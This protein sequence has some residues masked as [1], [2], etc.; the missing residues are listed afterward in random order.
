[1]QEKALNGGVDQ[2][3]VPLPIVC[4]KEGTLVYTESGLK[5]IEKII[6]GERIYSYSFKKKTEELSKVNGLIK[7]QATLLYEMATKNEMITVTSE[8][9]FYVLKRGWMKVRDLKVG[10]KIKTLGFSGGQEITRIK[11]IKYPLTVY[12]LE[13]NGNSNYYVTQSK[14]LV[15]NKRIVEFNRSVKKKK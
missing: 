6:A 11:T 14:L 3:G 2:N 1:M 5:P 7:R 10:Y 8:H 15:H 13:V 4:F 12:N 9:P